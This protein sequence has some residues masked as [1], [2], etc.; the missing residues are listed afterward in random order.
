MDSRP[1]QS[2]ENNVRYTSVASRE[3]CDEAISNNSYDLQ[4]E[5]SL[6]SDG[7]QSGIVKLNPSR[8]R[9]RYLN[10][11]NISVLL[12]ALILITGVS[13]WAHVLL[14]LKSF[15]CNTAPKTDR[16]EPDLL[17]SSRVTFQPH[18]Y[19]GGP[20]TN[21]TNEMWRRLSPPGDGIVAVPRKSTADLPPTLPSD[22]DPDID[23]YGISMFHQLHCLNFL[24]FAY[25]P[26]SITD[27]PPAEVIL[28][29]D[30]CLD[31]I[32]QAIMCNGDTTFEFVTEVG[33]NGMGVTHQ[34][35]DFEKLFSWAYEHRSDKVHGSGYTGG[36]LT[37]TPGH[38]NDFDANH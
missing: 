33:I 23:V 35:R 27:M 25:Y 14:L 26:D 19:Y 10:W 5:K 9:R 22:S 29:R 4:E 7:E 37:H 30:H 17:Y 18:Y 13:V 34:C 8:P 2:P 6:L 31:Y 11:P 12:S 38:R 1:Q 3:D 16:F 24:R 21:D 28:H 36:V 15:H 32:R 20:P